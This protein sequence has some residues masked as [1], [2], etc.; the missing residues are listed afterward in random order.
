MQAFGKIMGINTKCIVPE[1]GLPKV[2]IP[3]GVQVLYKD[4]LTQQPPKT[5]KACITLKSYFWRNLRFDSFVK[6]RFITNYCF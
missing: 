5:L 2:G 4:K 6:F 3:S 1:I